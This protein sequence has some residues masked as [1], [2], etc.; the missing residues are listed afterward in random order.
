[1]AQRRP[2][3]RLTRQAIAGQVGLV[4]TTL[5]QYYVSYHPV[6]AAVT[7]NVKAAFF[8][9][10]AIS[11]TGWT[12]KRQPDREGWFWLLSSDWQDGTGLSGREQVTARTV[13][14][15]L[16]V[17]EE[18]LKGVPAKIWY[19]V[20]V[21][22]LYQ[23]VAASTGHQIGT[24]SWD[25]AAMLH[26]LGQPIPCHRILIQAADGVVGGLILA[27]LFR[28]TRRDLSDGGDG[29]WMHIPV[30]HTREFLGISSKQQ[31]IARE[32][33]KASG[34]IEEAFEKAVQPKL[35]TRLNLA[36]LGLMC[37]E[38]S[39]AINRLRESSSQ[40]SESNKPVCGILQT[41]VAQS[42][43]LELPKAQNK[44]CPKRETGV[45]QSAKLDLRKGQLTITK[46]NYKEEQL[47]QTTLPEPSEPL[48]PSP[49]EPV[50]SGGDVELILPKTLLAGEALVART[51]L[52]PLPTELRQQVA[53]EWAGLISMADRGVRPLYNR[54]GMLR[55]LKDRAL[56]IGDQPFTPTIAFQ[57]AAAR[58]RQQQLE[59]LRHQP[60]PDGDKPAAR[61]STTTRE[62]AKSAMDQIAQLSFMRQPA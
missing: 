60:A 15:N 30:G 9:S 20:D 21:D 41:R 12:L 17:L 18:K 51:W 56:G 2:S 14:K 29:E 40:F 55:T 36:Q 45:A 6:L 23:V 3:N 4:S 54:M 49:T 44:E 28:A 38:M 62:A 42:A 11:W 61:S 37:A 43:K 57:V 33:L 46:E 31:R 1:M 10:H 7:G 47:Q 8:L 24:W 35:L 34:L 25:R 59:S 22:R 32:R 19:R 16:G 26:L 48:S 27:Y 39:N 53:D 13:L 52:S 58:L 50:C 5:G